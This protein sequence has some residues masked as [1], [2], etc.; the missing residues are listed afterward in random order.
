MFLWPEVVQTL[1]QLLA[2]RIRDNKLILSSKS[3]R[4]ISY[5]RIT[6]HNTPLN[7]VRHHFIEA[8]VF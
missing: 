6:R 2:S 8:C 7:A 3:K 4:E 5:Q 1:R